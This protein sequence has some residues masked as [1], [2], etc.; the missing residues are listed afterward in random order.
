MKIYPEQ[1][2]YKPQVYSTLWDLITY[3]YNDLKAYII[4]IAI[5]LTQSTAI[6]TF[7]VQP[8]PDSLPDAILR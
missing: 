1:M 5:R 2:Q 6:A 7:R 3:R 4:P 8:D